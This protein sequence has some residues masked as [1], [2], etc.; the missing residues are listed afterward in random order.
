MAQEIR[1]PQTKEPMAAWHIGST[2]E[3]NATFAYGPHYLIV[4]DGEIIGST[5]GTIGKKKVKLNKKFFKNLK[6]GLFS[7]KVKADIYAFTNG[8]FGS[9]FGTKIDGFFPRNTREQYRIIGSFSSY[10][11]I[12][13]IEKVYRTFIEKPGALFY[14][15]PNMVNVF[16]EI[17]KMELDRIA[18]TFT[19]P[20]S[21]YYLME[22]NKNSTDPAIH[23]IFNKYKDAMVRQYKEM[24]YKISINLGK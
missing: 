7:K 23:E 17:S 13:N 6:C 21:T 15:I 5:T 22:Y 3:K 20:K 18:P 14:T 2:F 10:F 1:K 16:S 9:Q 19:C 12:D 4:Q 24:G 8:F 11:L